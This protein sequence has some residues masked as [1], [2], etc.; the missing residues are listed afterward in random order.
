MSRLA[1][2]P[3]LLL[4]A[5]LLPLAAMVPATWLP[6]QQGHLADAWQQLRHWPA[7]GHSLALSLLS[8]LGASWGALV[9]G[10]ALA[11]RTLQRRRRHRLIPALLLAAPHIALATGLLM[12]LA[13]TGL[14]WRLLAPLFAWRQ[15]PDLALPNDPYALSLMLLLLLKETPFFYLLA[16]AQAE[17][18]GAMQQLGVA[19]ALGYPPRQGW[20]R[21]VV[22]Q[23]LPGLRLPMFC[24][25]AFSLSAL[26]LAL[27]L[28]P[29]RPYLFAQLLWQW[30][31]DGEQGG[32][33]ALGALLLLLLNALAL[34][35][36]Y[37]SERAWVNV[38]Q[39]PP[40]RHARHTASLVAAYW[41]AAFGL[42]ASAYLMLLLI[43]LA[44]RW[45]FPLRW[46]QH[47]RYDS[48]LYS[49]HD[50]ST[51]LWHSLWIAL[52]VNLLALILALGTLEWYAARQRHPGAWL[53]LPLLLPQ[54]GLIFGLQV[55]AARYHWLG[56]YPLVIYGQLLF[57][58]PYY[59]LTLS[60]PW[61]RF[62][63]RQI[64]VALALGQSPWRAFYRVKL[65]QLMPAL[66]VALAFGVAVSIGMYLPTLGLGAGRL[67]TLATETVAYASGIDRRLAA[68]GAL[69][70][71]LLP[72]PAFLLALWLPVRGVRGASRHDIS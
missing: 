30:I 21:I 41:P 42:T 23:L 31:S 11:G 13:P 1:L 37:A 8:S 57:V 24:V 70:Q 10:L 32:L 67:P 4:L 65:P 9:L 72:L 51:P 59:L 68:I 47:W 28:G 16:L 62:D 38:C 66:L 22:P 33:A 49:F 6:L 5:G 55:F 12:L 7:L 39:R 48:W 46:P 35:I 18:C 25:L 17:R 61:L 54:M 27:L 34:L 60:G 26:D 69:W 15:P 63:V 29:Q 36:S 58:T 44:Q 71:T 40:R 52:V 53:L 45:P 43:S 64:R 19:A 14:L 50:W 2:F 56:S 20:W 3:L